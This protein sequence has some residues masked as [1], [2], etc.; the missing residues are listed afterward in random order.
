MTD[1]CFD[2]SSSENSGKHITHPEMVQLRNYTLKSDDDSELFSDEKRD[3]VSV[4]EPRFVPP[5]EFITARKKD[6][7]DRRNI[8]MSI[9]SE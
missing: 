7:A 2:C 6:F 5:P 1:P 4:D 8:N 9:I 3:I